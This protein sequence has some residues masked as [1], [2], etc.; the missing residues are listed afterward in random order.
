[1]IKK[2]LFIL[3]LFLVTFISDKAS[4]S[5]TN[6]KSINNFGLE[7]VSGFKNRYAKGN[8]RKAFITAQTITF[9]SLPAKMFS[10]ADFNAGATASSGL[11]VNYTSS[12]PSVASVDASGTI[13]IY[14]AGTTVITASQ[15][16]D[17]NYSAA[18]PVQQTLVVYPGTQTIT[19][20]ATYKT[21]GDA[22]FTLSATASSGLPLIYTSNNPAVARVDINGQV[23]I[24]SAGNVI[25]TASQPG[26]GNYIATTNFNQPIVILKAPLNIIADNLTKTYGSANPPLTV[27]YIALVNGDTPA[28]FPAPTIAT[29]ATTTSDVGSYPITISG[30]ARANYNVTYQP[31]VLNIEKSPQSITA[32]TTSQKTYGDADFVLAASVASGLPLN[33]ASSDPSVATVDAAGKV[34]LLAAGETTITLTQ[35]GNSNYLAADTVNQILTVN[36]ASLNA[37]ADNKTTTYGAAI[38]A[39]TISYTGFVNGENESVLTASASANTTAT[40]TSPAGVY[41]I[42]AN[43][44]EAVNYNITYTAGTL[45]ILKAALTITADNK[46]KSYGTANPEFTVSYSGFVNA[47]TASVL[48]TPAVITTT[49]ATNS[50]VGIYP[51]AIAGAAAANYTITYVPGTLTITN[52]VVAGINLT[53]AT[54]FE[55]QPAG[56]VAGTLSASSLDLNQTFTY[57]LISG[58]GSADNASFNIQGNKLITATGL[59]YEQKASYSVLIRA[60]NQFGLYLDQAFAITISDVNEAPTLAAVSN[61]LAC[62]PS[63][64]QKIDL[65][66]ITAGPETAQRVTLSV[67]STNLDLFSSLTVSAVE[68]GTATLNYKLAG[69]G[70]AVVTVTVQDNGG[71]AN[72]GT[73]TF[74]QTFTIT[75]NAVPAG[76][77]A[78]DKTQ[79]SKGETVTL[80]AAGGSIYTWD[81]T[82]N[83]SGA[84]NSPVIQ[85]RPERTTTYQVKISNASGCSDTK[86]ITI[87]VADDYSMLQPANI[88]TPNGDGKNDT[89]VVKNIDLYPDNTVLIFDRGGRKLLETKHYNNDWDGSLNGSPLTEGT[90]YYVIDFGSGKT[91]MKGFITIL[92]NR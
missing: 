82:P 35:N 51:I 69:T 39:L 32:A 38:P 37:A 19:F 89:W 43:G 78:A 61:Q 85:V 23:H 76:T 83:M 70:S 81:T 59:D 42:T 20:P 66:G 40:A 74:T 60:T 24:V 80:T 30:T 72:G 12:N 13:H 33:F 84:S 26:N 71:T 46:T 14:T 49:A 3:I 63:S 65:T 9:S 86:S 29:T 34:H 16:G 22:D 48:S 27:T 62:Y 44:A 52:A 92:R 25:I 4:A 68:N 64:N 31:G 15:P 5:L 1:M 45:T 53:Q 90:Y 77:L 73:N 36:K 41:P 47:E 87:N 17:S 56:T 55:N 18:V 11:T 10:D 28:S 21:Y 79:I 8:D 7:E 67:S 88:L 6:G 2:S 57:S 75:V 54:V 58:T 50:A 91:P